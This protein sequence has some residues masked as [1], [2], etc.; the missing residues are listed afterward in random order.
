MEKKIRYFLRDQNIFAIIF[1]LLISFGF[2]SFSFSVSC[3]SSLSTSTASHRVHY[4]AMSQ[5]SYFLKKTLFIVSGVKVR[6]L[7]HFPVGGSAYS[8]QIWVRHMKD[9]LAYRG[10]ILWNTVRFID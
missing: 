2:Q 8:S 1:A 9:S 3:L 6:I 7:L 4:Q 10:A 5:E